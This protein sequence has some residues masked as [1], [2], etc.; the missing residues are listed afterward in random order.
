MTDCKHNPLYFHIIYCDPPK[1]ECLDCHKTFPLPKYRDMCSNYRK[2]LEFAKR[3]TDVG[4]ICCLKDIEIM[5]TEL[6]KELGE[7]DETP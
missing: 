3:M 2:L 6:L 5:A 4:D 7:L 1:M